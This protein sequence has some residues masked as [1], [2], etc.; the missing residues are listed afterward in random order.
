MNDQMAEAVRRQRQRS[1][2]SMMVDRRGWTD[3]QWVM[4]AQRL[5]D[6]PDGAI[7]SLVNGHVMA[8]LRIIRQVEPAAI[9]DTGAADSKETPTR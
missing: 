2:E 9:G 7:T 5:M 6:E 1:R 8:M 4:D 3:A